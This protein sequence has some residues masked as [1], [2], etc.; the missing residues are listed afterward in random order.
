M[1]QRAFA[2][3]QQIRVSIDDLRTDMQ[4]ANQ[5]PCVEAQPFRFLDL[6]TE[7]RAMIMKYSL[8]VGT[9]F[10]RRRPFS[11]SRLREHETFAVPDLTLLKICRQIRAEAAKVLFTTNHIV[12]NYLPGAPQQNIF[13]Q[14]GCA[15]FLSQDIT[16]GT[17]AREMI[18]SLSITL[19]LRNAMD[20][21]L[22]V[23]DGVASSL[24]RN[25]A[26]KNFC[27]SQERRSADSNDCIEGW[28]MTCWSSLRLAISEAAS[29]R[30]L[31]VNVEN[32]V[33]PLGCHRL[34]DLVE[35]TLR[36]MKFSP[37]IKVLEICGTETKE[38]RIQICEALQDNATL[39][40]SQPAVRF[41][42]LRPNPTDATPAGEKG[43]RMRDVHCGLQDERF[44]LGTLILAALEEA[45][46][47]KAA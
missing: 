12:M 16:F 25:I 7:L 9:F 6:P 29:I 4:I 33:C 38:E 19:D 17:F 47:A 32:A 14:S 8:A 23:A 44:E 18:T 10:I 43:Y 37:Y 2:W 41:T 42:T 40:L 5:F 35:S 30:F 13:S 28:Y 3:K 46:T 45:S 1:I 27:W 15:R 24:A 26:S 34:L 39:R 11:D 36:T 31:Q 20:D 21:Q 22:E